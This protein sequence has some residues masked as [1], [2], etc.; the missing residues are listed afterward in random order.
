MLHFV[1][2]SSNGII[3]SKREE[4]VLGKDDC[5]ERQLTAHMPKRIEAAG[6]LV[7]QNYCVTVEKLAGTFNI[8]HGSCNG[9]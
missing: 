7:H 9:V 4:K 5:A 2:P 1:L 8:S 3:G 6:Q